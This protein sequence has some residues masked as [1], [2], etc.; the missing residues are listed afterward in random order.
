MSRGGDSGE[1]REEMDA[2]LAAEAE[3]LPPDADGEER[4]DSAFV[5]SCLYNNA[6][7]DG[8]LFARIMRGRFVQV[9]NWGKAGVWLQWTGHHWAIDKL[10]E[11]VN[12]VEE[13]ALLYLQEATRL[14]D[15]IKTETNTDQAKRMGAERKLYLRRVERLRG[16]G[17]RKCL[18]W[19][20][21]IGA[22]HSLAIVADDIDL[23]PWLLPCKNGVID[24]RTGKFR[25]GRPEEYLLR[26]VPIDWQGLD[27]PCPTWDKFISEIHGD[28]PAIVG[29]LDRLIGYTLT[30]LTTEHFIGVFLGEGRNGKGTLF[31]TLRHL[32]G[33]LAWNVSPELLMEQ[34]NARSSA[35]P[36]PDLISLQGRRM[37]IASESDDNRRISG[38]QVKRL[39]G[40]DTITARAP[41]D[42]DETNI[43]P[44]WKLFFYTNHIPRGMADDFA[45]KDRLVYIDYPY[46]YVEDP[47][48]A[49]PSQKKRDPSLPQ[50]LRAEAA[51]I[52]ARYV[53]GCLEW[54]ETGGL[55][56]PLKIRTAVDDLQRREDVFR[57]FFDECIERI[58]HPSDPARLDEEVR[59]LFKDLYT[60]FS[61]WFAE[62]VS[63]SD[64][65]R[66]SKKAVSA[67]LEKRGF[68]RSKP[69]G[70]AHVHGIRPRVGDL[71]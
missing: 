47:D 59:M 63:D 21:Q 25:P 67:W 44:S 51:G 8:I 12:A 64:R 39:T 1:I 26:A 7:G 66:P 9:K 6:R 3:L 53:R 2:L 71:T 30:G 46:K 34:R 33:D 4:P 23:R 13:V 62:E 24:L 5:R 56:P 60:L 32:L 55:H 65:F 40:G 19:A 58:P 54:Q 70:I 14:K 22:A 50:K 49:D 57:Q 68:R 41:H 35:G 28:D 16:D 15:Q 36:S 27:C 17:A 38:Q 45:L 10:D 31:E 11:A 61:T 43:L 69:S 48:P 20:T 42:R 29:F 52:L 37:V 18:E